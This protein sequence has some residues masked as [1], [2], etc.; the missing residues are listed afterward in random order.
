MALTSRLALACAV[1]CLALSAG[2]RELF[3]G[4]DL[5]NWYTFIKGRGANCDP[6]G[7]FTVTNGVIHVSGEEFGC[8]TSEEDFS[9]YHLLVEYRWTGGPHFGSKRGK[10]PDSGILFHSIGPDGGF[11]GTWMMSHEYNLVLGAPGDLWTVGRKDRPDIFVE[12]E[13]GGELLDGRYRIHEVGGRMVRLVGND[14]LCRSDIA[15][16]WKDAFD[17]APA[18]NERPVGEWNVAEVICR[19]EQAEFRFN[20]KTVNR[21]TRLSP[22][23]GRI[24]LQSEGCPVEFRRVEIRPF[25]AVEKR[26]MQQ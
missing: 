6:R 11:G 7:V 18:V 25:P 10:A 19:G 12:G 1:A 24:Q 17:V 21:L 9:D 3:N 15:R 8:L 5:S 4:K 26:R 20:G 2:A 13:A 23:R 14:R 16:D 22:A